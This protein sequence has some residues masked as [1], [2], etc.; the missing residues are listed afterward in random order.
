[1]SSTLKELFLFLHLGP[2]QKN[3][4]HTGAW[5]YTN[6]SSFFYLATT[7]EHVTSRRE[8][9]KQK[10]PLLESPCCWLTNANITGKTSKRKY[11]RRSS[12]VRRRIGESHSETAHTTWLL[13]LSVVIIEQTRTESAKKKKTRRV[14]RDLTEQVSSILDHLSHLIQFFLSALGAFPS[15][16]APYPQPRYCCSVPWF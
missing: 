12:W 13:G 3:W 2:D 5:K 14:R 10:A 6:V 16:S 8:L 4:K 11:E 1:M 9:G 7:W 15:D